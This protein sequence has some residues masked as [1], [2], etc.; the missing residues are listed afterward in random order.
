MEKGIS[1]LDAFR[2]LDDIGDE[3][4]EEEIKVVKKNQQLKESKEVIKLDISGNNM[5]DKGQAYFYARTG[6]HVD[7]NGEKFEIAQDDTHKIGYSDEI[8]LKNLKTGETTLIAKKDFIKDAQLLKEECEIEEASSAEKKAFKNGGEDYADYIDGKAI[9]RVKDPDERARLVAVKK[10][11]KSGKLA[12]RPTVQQEL[13][14]KEKQAVDAFDKKQQT[15]ADKG[16][17]QEES[18][19]EKHVCEKCGKEPCE[20]VEVKEEKIEEAPVYGL[21]PEFDSRKSFYG[22]ANVDVKKDGTQVLYSYDTPVCM[23]KDGEVTLGKSRMRGYPICV[24]NY[25]PTTLRHVKEFLKQNGFKAES[26][27]QIGQD[28]KCDFINES[29]TEDVKIDLMD[30]DAVE[31]GKEALEQQQEEPVEQI[32]DIDADT[33][34]DLKDSYVG[35]IVIKCHKCG[36][37]F[38]T[39][40]DSLVK[41]EETGLYNVEEKCNHCGAEEGFELVGQVATAD[42]DA[43]KA[44]EQDLP[45]K[46]E[47]KEVDVE[48][49]EEPKEV[50]VETEKEETTDGEEEIKKTSIIAKESLD[51]RSLIE[52][53]EDFDDVN[54]DTLVNKYFNKVYENVE[55]YKTTNCKFEDNSI[56]VEGV[57]KFNSGKEK[58]TS[59]K[60]KESKQ[61][62]VN[63]RF[64]CTNESLVNQDKAFSLV[65]KVINNNL[66]CESF[67]CN[68]KVKKL[69]EELLVRERFSLKEKKEKK[70]EEEVK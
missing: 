46:E 65:G 13:D 61:N 9:A 1:I 11:E 60:L 26:T 45:V 16:Y 58:P 24:W 8:L 55:S 52:K 36:F 64:D 10:L 37:K 28:Y 51:T 63:V 49:K 43:E 48:V 15:M 62:K 42:I 67:S 12:E 69:E 40:K 44:D 29:L 59:F 66:I 54:F 50:E 68:Y 20:C 33:V 3:F 53:L 7:I 4:V 14:R 47:E 39:D 35:D 38:F 31:K 23:I 32:V 2:A 18:L 5:Y 41:D 25:S 19:E 30:K 34:D 21:E 56:I 6:D 70:V 27:K 22:K 57:I 17:A